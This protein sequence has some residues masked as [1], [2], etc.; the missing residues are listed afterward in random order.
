MDDNVH[1]QNS[2]QF[3]QELQ[4]ANKDSFEVMFYPRSRHG[5]LSR[6]YQ[7]LTIDFMRRAL[8]IPGEPVMSTP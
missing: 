3:I 4:Q 1:M 5:I 6:H 7:R 2:L 8:N